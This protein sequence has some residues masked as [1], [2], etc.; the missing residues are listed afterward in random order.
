MNEKMLH[1][2]S[3]MEEED[4]LQDT[5]PVS[6]SRRKINELYHRINIGARN[7]CKECERN[8]IPIF[9]AYFLPGKGYRYRAAFPEEIETESVK[10]EYGKFKQF[11]KVCID[12]NKNDYDA[13]VSVSEKD[14]TEE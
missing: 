13:G 2:V 11:L 7:F 4:T 3:N 6:E 1:V 5:T 14:S 9:L 8:G 10:S 12:F